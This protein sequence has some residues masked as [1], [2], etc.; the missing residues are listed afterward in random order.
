M[1]KKGPRSFWDTFQMILGTS[2]ILTFLGPIIG[3]FWARRPRIYSFSYAKNTS[4][5]I[6]KYMG[7]SWKN[8]IFGNLR[9]KK[10]E[11]SGP[12]VHPTFWIFEIQKF[13][14]LKLIHRDTQPHSHI[15]TQ[16]HSHRATQPHSY[17]AT[18]EIHKGA[19]AEGR[20]P[21]VEAAAGRLLCGYVAMWL[22]GSV[23]MQLCSYVAIWLCGYVAMWLCGYVDQF[24]KFKFL[25]FKDP[26][27]WVHT[28]SRIF[29]FFESQISKDNISPGCSHIFSIIF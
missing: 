29:E 21:F 14:I 12:C 1:A 4:K 18:K 19:A 25:N 10:F 8:I 13:E 27:S 17:V 26:K 23:A 20:R 24:Q 7:T 11:H 5:N 2:K 3:H 9:P 16:L 15:A 6:R 28:W 22:C